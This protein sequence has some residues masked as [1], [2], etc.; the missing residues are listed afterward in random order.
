[1]REV[2]LDY[3]WLDYCRRLFVNSLLEMV[4]TLYIRYA[5]P[6]GFTYASRPRSREP[7][8]FFPDVFVVLALECYVVDIVYFVI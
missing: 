5:M 2:T 3:V 6:Q 1:M 7:R 4:Y 8:F